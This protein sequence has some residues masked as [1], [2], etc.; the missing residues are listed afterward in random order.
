[1]QH[2]LQDEATRGGVLLWN[3]F[4]RLIFKEK[5]VK[6]AKFIWTIHFPALV[7]QRQRDLSSTLGV[8]D[9]LL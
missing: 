3:I 9:I 5:I 8:E 7:A 4:N 2:N 6:K 1:M